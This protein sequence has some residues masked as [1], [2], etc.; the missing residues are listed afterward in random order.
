MSFGNGTKFSNKRKYSEG[1]HLPELRT[2]GELEMSSDE[3]TGWKLSEDEDVI[4]EFPEIVTD[5]GDEDETEEEDDDEDEKSDEDSEPE[6]LHIFPKAKNVV[7]E[8]TKHPKLV[9]P[10]IEP[11]YDSDSS[12]EDV[13]HF[14]N[15]ETYP[16][17]FTSSIRHPTELG[18]FL[19][20]G[21]MIYHT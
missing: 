4:D 7:S 18:I 11:D 21:T 6:S 20:T 13:S 16:S 10:E 5:S 9:Y 12:T 2:N 8:I 1:T 19:C 17:I 14:F 3:E 15:V